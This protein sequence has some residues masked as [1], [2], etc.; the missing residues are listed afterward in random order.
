MYLESWQ[1]CP[2]HNLPHHSSLLEVASR[3]LKNK[4]GLQ[5]FRLVQA[6]LEYH[7]PKDILRPHSVFDS[8]W[9]KAEKNM[10]RVQLG[11]V[12]PGYH[13][14]KPI[15]FVN[16][17]M[18]E[19]KKT[20]LVNWLSAHLLWI[21][22]VSVH[23]PSK[24]PSPQM[25]RDF[26]NTIGTDIS[27]MRSASMKSAVQDILGENIIHAAQGSA[28]VP[29]EIEWRGMQASS[30]VLFKYLPFQICL[31]GSFAPFCGNY[32]SSTFTMSCM[33][34]IRSL[35]PIFGQLTKPDWISRAFFTA[36]SLEPH[37][38]GLCASSMSIMLPYWNNFFSSSLKSRYRELLV[39]NMNLAMYCPTQFLHPALNHHSHCTLDCN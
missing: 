32:M 36:F 3:P 37:E 6:L 13:F 4:A 10:Q 1:L 17:T 16:V 29:E 19:W 20:Y 7:P 14:L 5:G 18:L 23:S 11:L 38:L 8:A 31:S 39:R 25:W 26:L 12:N 9:R 33:H 2:P 22:Q 15:L 30:I 28:G 21:S 27:S 34:L 35:Y 24:F